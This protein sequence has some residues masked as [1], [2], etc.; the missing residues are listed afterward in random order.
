MS[1]SPSVS[2]CPSVYLVSFYAVLLDSVNGKACFCFFYLENTKE[3]GS[4]GLYLCL[5]TGHSVLE[6]I[7]LMML[8]VFSPFNH[9]DFAT[10]ISFL[11]LCIDA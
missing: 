6:D 4:K 10:D 2:I 1:D 5:Y 3:V 8:L 11:H 7:A 9:V